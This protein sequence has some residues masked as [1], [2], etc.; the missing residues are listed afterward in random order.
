MLPQVPLSPRAPL[1][2]SSGGD[3]GFVQVLPIVDD[4]FELRSPV[5]RPC[6]M[7]DRRNPNGDAGKMVVDVLTLSDADD[8]HLRD[9][10]HKALN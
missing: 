6:L 9:P 8:P 3:G 4:G 1:D 10:W 7:T 2:S 5:Q